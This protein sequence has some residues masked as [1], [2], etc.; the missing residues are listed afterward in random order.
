MK[1]YK[2][3]YLYKLGRFQ[4]DFEYVFP[5]IKIIKY[6]TDDKITS[7]NNIECINIKDVKTDLKDL[8]VVCDRKNPATIKKFDKLKLI[9]NIHY[10]FLEDFGKILDE[11]ESFKEKF[12]KQQFKKKFSFDLNNDSK[13]NSELFKEIIYADVKPN[14][15]C[16]SPFYFAQVNEKG[17][18]YPCCKGWVVEHIGSIL[19]NTT[20]KL[21]HSTRA[22]IF[23]LS[24]I[25]RTYA[26]CRLD[27]CQ[28]SETSK[29]D[30]DKFHEPTK[31]PTWLALAY[32][33]TCNLSCP[34]CRRGQYSLNNSKPHQNLYDRIEKSMT[35]GNWISESDTL[36]VSNSGESL[37]SN[38]Y[39]KILFSNKRDKN[40]TVVIHSNGLLLTEKNLNKLC[41]RYDKIRIFISLDSINEE[42]YKKLRRGSSLKIL[43]KNL[44]YISRLKKEGKIQGVNIMA[45]VQKDNYMEL[46]DLVK[47]TIELGFD[48]FDATRIFNFGS[49]TEE[50]FKEVSMYDENSNPKPELV[51][52]LKDPIFKTTKIILQGNVLK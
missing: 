34:S 51:E 31:V 46:P 13:S 40:K 30:I 32:D 24:V 44:E 43:K 25:N 5:D 22:R 36:V 29:H 28:L 19:Y 17:Y 11:K 50:E 6:I 4:E 16:S 39:K 2:K 18:I 15:D 3:V 33:Q 20:E 35:K 47:F 38:S 45:V 48:C 27:N 8:I 42:T 21:W 52:V 26:F 23:R 37:F 49:F 12:I 7:Y 14:L 1:K 41:S 10:V 9:E